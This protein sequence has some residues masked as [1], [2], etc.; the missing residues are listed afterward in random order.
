MLDKNGEAPSRCA[1][2]GLPVRS[3]LRANTGLG[4][5]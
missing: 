5:T 4:V 2:R 1:R 3:P